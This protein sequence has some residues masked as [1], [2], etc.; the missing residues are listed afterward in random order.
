MEAIYKYLTDSPIFKTVE[1][2]G[3]N[4]ITVPTG[5]VYDDQTDIILYF[6][7]KCGTFALTDNGR[8][9]TYMDKIFDLQEDDVIKNILGVTSCYGISTKNKQL[10]FEIGEVERFE[11]LKMLFC[12]DFLDTM[13]IFYT[14]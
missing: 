13:K 5:C 9:R 4:E 11:F 10:S 14:E 6:T 2:I 3:D 12:I 1:I 8:T 7:R